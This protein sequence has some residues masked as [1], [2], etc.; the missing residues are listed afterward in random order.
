MTR[1]TKLYKQSRRGSGNRTL[2]RLKKGRECRERLRNK[3]RERARLGLGDFVENESQEIDNSVLVSWNEFGEHNIETNDVEVYKAL[4]KNLTNF[5]EKTINSLKD[6]NKCNNLRS[7][8]IPRN[9]R[10][11]TD[12]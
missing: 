9:C 5:G 8:E 2:Q 1:K 4:E 6:F 3:L 12:E 11:I 10:V 7:V